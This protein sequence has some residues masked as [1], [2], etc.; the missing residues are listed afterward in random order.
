[1]IYPRRQTSVVIEIPTV[2]DLVWLKYP[3]R[4][5]L[6]VVFEIP[7]PLSTSCVGLK[8]APWWRRDDPR[9][10]AQL[11]IAPLKRRD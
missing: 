1:M 9:L 8:R 2:V 6:V 7:K 11:L 10:F 4:D 5:D 3:S